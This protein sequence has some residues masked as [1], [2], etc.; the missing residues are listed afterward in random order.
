MSVIKFHVHGMLIELA[1]NWLFHTV[2][3]CSGQFG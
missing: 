3:V 1:V 2:S